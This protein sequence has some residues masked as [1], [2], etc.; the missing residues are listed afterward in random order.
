MY[1]TKHNIFT[2]LVICSRET[3]T[4]I[5]KEIVQECMIV[6]FFVSAKIEKKNPPSLE[7]G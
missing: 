7:L 1:I 2:P 3:P 6:A 5:D 4:Y